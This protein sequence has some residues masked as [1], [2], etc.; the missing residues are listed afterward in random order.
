MSVVL[1][2]AGKKYTI[3]SASVDQIILEKAAALFEAAAQEIQNKEVAL[4]E[5]QLCAMVTMRCL[6]P[7]L[8]EQHEQRQVL[9]QYITELSQALGG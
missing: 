6:V 5:G 8:Q 1:Q 7:L 9:E 4:S 3:A 2:L